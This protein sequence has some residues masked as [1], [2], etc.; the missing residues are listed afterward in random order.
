MAVPAGNDD[1][2]TLSELCRGIRVQPWESDLR[3]TIAAAAPG[4][5]GVPAM[6]AL[7]ELNAI[8]RQ[9]RDSLSRLRPFTR[10]LDRAGIERLRRSGVLA[11]LLDLQ[12]HPWCPAE[13]R[14]EVYGTLLSVVTRAS[15]DQLRS[16]IGEGC[17]RLLCKATRI[18]V[19]PALRRIVDLG[20]S[21]RESLGRN[22]YADQ[23]EAEGGL[24]RLRRIREE[25]PGA[26]GSDRIEPLIRS[27]ERATREGGPETTDRGLGWR[28]LHPFLRHRRFP[29]WN[30]EEAAVPA[31]E[32]GCP[33][34]TKLFISHRWSTP[35]DPDPEQKHLPMVV[36]YLSRVFMVANGLLR[37]D[38]VVAKELAVGH[39]LR[40]AFDESRL[41]RCRC[42]S[43]GWLDLRS[44]LDPDDLF[45]RGVPDVVRRRNFYRLLKHVRVWYDYSSLP[46]S[47]GT[48]ED[49]EFLDRALTHLADVVGGAEVLALWGVDSTQR[50]WC[51]FEVLAARSVHFCSP[52]SLRWGLTE[53]A[54]A[55]GAL[56]GGSPD[57]SE[58]LSYRGRPGASIRIAVEEFKRGV[59]GLSEPEIHDYLVG[60]GFQCT[61]PSDLVRLARLIRR[62]IEEGRKANEPG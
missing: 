50:A 43:V 53:S 8:E 19:L 25:D 16:L 24:D 21:D 48:E 38:S 34:A 3:R 52:G 23:I 6:R 27:I 2:S 40:E 15:D 31:I 59:T 54:A 11:A 28:L 61:R 5:L 26:P 13:I 1:L 42:R 39:G 35:E 36:E 57:R 22:R 56:G 37:E 45:F 60:K 9:R 14:E 7:G 33:L 62:H 44:L 18:D 20:E 4:R 41:D 30:R 49:E 10:E 32:E 51:V 12:T 17:I 58:L 55:K 47:R 29:V 46:Q